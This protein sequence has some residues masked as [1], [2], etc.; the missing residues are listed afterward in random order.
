MEK[1]KKEYVLIN[2][3]E[4]LVRK[5]A[6]ELMADY[7]I[8]KCE[9]CFLDVCAIVLNQSDAMY[10]TTEKGKLLQLLEATDYQFKTDLVVM[11]L[12]AMKSVKENPKH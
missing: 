3:A 6:R 12:Q 5:K 9:K 2:I 1:T 4:E 8:C 11:I 10:Y 7:D